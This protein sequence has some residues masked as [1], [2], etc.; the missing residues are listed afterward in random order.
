MTH[1]VTVV[2]AALGLIA[3]GC[4]TEVQAAGNIL[5]F[6]TGAG[7]GI[8]TPRHRFSNPN[9]FLPRSVSGQEFGWDALVGIRPIRWVGA[10]VQYMDFG[11]THLGPSYPIGYPLPPVSSYGF[12]GANGHTYA[13]GAFAVG[14]LPFPLGRPWLDLFAKVGES[15]LWVSYSYYYP[16]LTG[17]CTSAGV[18][19]PAEV[20]G[21]A[22]TSE[23]DFS[24]GGGIQVHFGI[25]AVRAEYEAV[26]SQ[27]RS[28]SLFS[29]GLV[30]TP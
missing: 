17:S 3:C 16:S 28:P 8:G 11:H 27:Y 15:R 6:Y 19:S 12:F 24:Y 14:Y 5:H 26:D 22:N 2:L 29:V 4:A 25:F 1:R 7:I 10:E 21:T 20:A 13:A 18:C 9:D 30:W 23:I